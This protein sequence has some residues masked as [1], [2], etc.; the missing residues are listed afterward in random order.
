M[1]RALQVTVGLVAALF[2]LAALMVFEIIDTPW[3][4]W[5][6]HQRTIELIEGIE[7]GIRTYPQEVK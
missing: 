3:E 1:T 2:T 5:E 4:A 7:W 6:E